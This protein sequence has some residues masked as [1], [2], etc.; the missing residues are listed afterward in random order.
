[1]PPSTMY[2]SISGQ[3]EEAAVRFLGDEAHRVFDA[4]AIVPAAI[5]Y[6]D[7]ARGGKAF[8][9]A[10]NEHLAFFAV[11]QGAGGGLLPVP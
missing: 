8:D 5:E 2:F 3:R 9:V 6:D 1:M 4:G 7:L 10:L 11:R